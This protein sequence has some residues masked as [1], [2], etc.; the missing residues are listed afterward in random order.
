[1][2]QF[3]GFPYYGDEYKVM[4]LAPYGEPIY[5]DK[6]CEIVKLKKNGLFELE[7]SF[8]I[9]ES[10]GVD[11]SWQNGMPN[12]GVLYSDKLVKFFGK[13][14]EKD[15]PLNQFHKDLAASVQKMCEEVIFNALN[16]LHEFTN[17]E[18][19]CV[20][21]GVAQNSVANGKITRETP[22]K[23][24][25]IP[26]AGHDAGTCI[27][28]ALYHYNHNLK[29]ARIEPIFDAY[30]GSR[31]TTKDI[32]SLL[33][34][35]KIQYEIVAS[36]QELFEIVSERLINAGVV[37]WFQ[38][39]SEFGPRALGSRSI[40]ADPSR[41]DAKDLINSK[42]KRRES[43]RPFA[44]SI[45]E[46]YV[47]EYFEVVENAPFMEKVFPIKE[48]KRKIIP[49][50]THVDGSGRLQTVNKE[51]TPKYY[52]LI[53]TFRKKSGIPLVLNTSFNENEP[54]VNTPA[55]A[56][57]CFLRTQMDML[58]MENVVVKR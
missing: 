5:L 18:N 37:G 57:D 35:K 26:S 3:L 12:I 22:F 30:S 8:F 13:P 23:N 54:I 49:A 7:T 32:T 2:T 24:L 39:R 20:T 31:F 11:M 38:G 16:Y 58:V 47:G 15:E 42:I 4:G 50:V 9:H 1:M 25:Y 55:E 56:L 28:S 27:G 6:L 19:I 40:L 51:H 44:P 45:L 43:F 14:R 10:K 48:E 29:Q 21:G 36:D 34:E 46:E 33:D 53:E 52:Q 17:C 41:Q